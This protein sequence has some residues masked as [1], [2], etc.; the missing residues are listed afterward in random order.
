MR[1][2]IQCWIAAGQKVRRRRR[3]HDVRLNR[4]RIGIGYQPEMPRQ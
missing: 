2:G 3:R 4:W 1:R